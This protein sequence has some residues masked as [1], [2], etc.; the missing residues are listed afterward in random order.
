MKRV[1]G[2]YRKIGCRY[3]FLRPSPSSTNHAEA[4]DFAVAFLSLEP[5]KR[6]LERLRIDNIAVGDLVYDSY[7]R[8]GNTTIDF[9]DPGIKK[10]LVETFLTVQFWLKTLQR[11]PGTV[12]ADNVYINAV[13]ARVAASLGLDVYFVGHENVF[14]QATDLPESGQSY[15]YYKDWA[16]RLSP[17]NKQS[18]LSEGKRYVEARLQGAV[19]GRISH[20]MEDSQFTLRA[21]SSPI[22]FD[23]T[24]Q[25]VLV[26]CHDF[27]DSPHVWGTNIFP[28]FYEWLCFLADYA[29]TSPY[30][31][32]L[33]PHPN[34]SERDEALLNRLF[35]DSPGSLVLSRQTK[36]ADV[37]AQN[38]IS[39]A[40]TVC[41][42][43]ASE[44]PAIGI[45]VIN[46]SVN[47]PHRDFAFSISPQTEVELAK[48]LDKVGTH[49]Q[50]VAMDDL[51]LY[52][53]FHNVLG[54]TLDLAQ[55][56]SDPAGSPSGTDTTGLPFRF[57]SNVSIPAA[58]RERLTSFIN[59]YRYM[60]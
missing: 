20:Y 56:L 60:A 18:A 10:L 3:M 23:R 42:T 2:Q 40:L 27:Y 26:A 39:A 34:S 37:L 51:Y 14:R 46:A 32:L 4:T 47:N 11:R 16:R 13:P 41:G 33:K 1:E 21:H 38:K 59:D 48:E 28:D 43:I 57:R 25:T 15:R 9:G 31:W 17:E 30:R 6:D 45:P 55:H 54:P 58:V 52:H 7:L 22:K 44:L 19:E 24:S 36:L 5:T 8:Q 35:G 29:K 49:D 50:P 53:Y 12:I